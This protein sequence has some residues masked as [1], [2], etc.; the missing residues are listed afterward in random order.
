MLKSICR[1][2]FN[3]LFLNLKNMATRKFKTY[4]LWLA[5]VALVIFLLNSTGQEFPFK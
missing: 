1:M 2:N 4:Y 5:F 3:H